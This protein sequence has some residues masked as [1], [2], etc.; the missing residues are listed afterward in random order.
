M[1]ETQRPR[2][3]SRQLLLIRE[4]SEAGI[5]PLAAWRHICIRFRKISKY[6]ITWLIDVSIVSSRL[7]VRASE[8]TRRNLCSTA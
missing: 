6:S 5:E 3:A 7:T 2:V 4:Q 8:S 1:I